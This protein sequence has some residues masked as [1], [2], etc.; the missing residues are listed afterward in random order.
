MLSEFTATAGHPG[1]DTFDLGHQSIILQLRSPKLELFIIVDPGRQSV[2]GDTI[3]KIAHD[4]DHI[5]PA[6]DLSALRKLDVIVADHIWMIR[7][8]ELRA[9]RTAVE[10]GVGFLQQAGF[11][12]FVPSYSREVMTMQGV[13]SNAQWYENRNSTRCAVVAG[14]HELLRGLKA[15]QTVSV[16]HGCGTIGPLAGMTPLLLPVGAAPNGADPTWTD[17]VTRQ[18][19]LARAT[20]SGTE[21]GTERDRK[22]SARDRDRELHLL[23][24]VCRQCRRRPHRRMSVAQRMPG[25]TAADRRRGFLPP[26]HR[27]A[28][29]S[30]T[31]LRGRWIEANRCP[32][33]HAAGETQNI[34]RL[35]AD[36]IARGDGIIGILLALLLP[37]LSRVR[38]ASEH[39]QMCR[40]A[41]PDRSGDRQ[42]R[43][44]ERRHAAAWSGSHYYPETNVNDPNGPGW[45]ALLERYSGAKADS[46]LYQCPA[47]RGADEMRV[48]TYLLAARYC[49]SL[50]PPTKSFPVSRIRLSS[51]FLLSS[52]V[53]NEAWYPQPLG[54]NFTPADNVDKD[55]NLMPCLLF[56]GEEGGFNMHRAGNNVLFADGHVAP[57][58]TFDPQSLTLSPVRAA[59]L[60]RGGAEQ[61]AVRRG[62]RGTEA[63]RGATRGI[64]AGPG[65]RR[66]GKDALRD[67]PPIQRSVGGD[68]FVAPPVAQSLQDRRIAVRRR[69]LTRHPSSAKSS[70]TKL[71]PLPI[72]PTMPM[73]GLPANTIAIVRDAQS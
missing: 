3:E 69:H 73:T 40:A 12:V 26:L 20:E 31:G 41:S 54:T 36:R 27:M 49:G 8:D 42:L 39:H 60:G 2:F 16:H 32:C 25:R 66:I 71:L 46:P 72:P 43:G 53:T 10:G 50:K 34:A 63:P 61:H 23:P 1:N 45:I 52:D 37:V 15:G 11:A 56:F 47:M 65:G 38:E 21:G 17:F 62:F 28:G 29:S 70:A 5:I 33:A 6:N 55:D 18:T 22:H 30:A 57:V 4:A 59:E 58:R 14:E 9:I 68:H 13:A 64:S 35:L 19:R 67:G 24:A 48:V 51:Q 44:R 7:P